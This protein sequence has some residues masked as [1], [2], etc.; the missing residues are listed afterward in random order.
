MKFHNLKRIIWWLRF[1]VQRFPRKFCNT[2]VYYLCDKKKVI[3]VNAP[4]F[5][6]LGKI[7]PYNIG[8]D[9][10]C[11]LLEALSGKRVFG[12]WT[13]YHS[14]DLSSVMAIG[15][16]ID[17]YGNKQ[18]T[19]WGAG[20]LLPH[21]TSHCGADYHEYNI[22]KVCAVRG[23]KTRHL[24]IEAG[25]DC[26][27]VYGDPALLMPYIYN[28]QVQRIK[29]RIGFIPHYVDLKDEHF[30]RLINEAGEDAL[31]INV[32]NYKSW[33]DVI[34]QICSCDFVV[35]SSLHGLILSDAYGVPNLWVTL[36]KALPGGEFKF[37]DYYSAVGK[38]PQPFKICDDTQLSALVEK[39]RNY[40]F[41]NFDPRPL[42]RACPFEIVHSTIKSLLS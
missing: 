1:H 31:L 16:V 12:N 4:I 9:L 28:P 26:P 6:T 8:D 32:Q 3:V 5:Q 39:K 25:I 40:E 36:P 30:K 13:F 18:S 27:E 15:S 17:Q 14:K 21:Q 29:G 33:K 22:K 19:V 41:I 7:R 42:L 20:I 38:V 35:S 10:N 34:N 24:L 37:E 23:K 2:V 11:P